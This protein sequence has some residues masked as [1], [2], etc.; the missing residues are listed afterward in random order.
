MSPKPELRARM[1]A[2]RKLGRGFPILK[3]FL[4]AVPAWTGARIVAAYQAMRGEF[5]VTSAVF[6]AHMR[7]VAVAFPRVTPGGLVFHVW[8][9]SPMVPGPFGILEPAPSLPVVAPA[10]LDVLLVPGLAFDPTGNRLGHG[11]GYY[12][13]VLAGPRGLTIGVAWSSQVVPEVPTDPWDQP[14]DALLTERGW[15]KGG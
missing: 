3:P 11:A 13:R 12:D 5:P 7:G 9:G 6:D 2:L 1:R 14:V 15:V 10:D 4:R 8:D